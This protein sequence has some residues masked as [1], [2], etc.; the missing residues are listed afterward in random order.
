VIDRE[1]I[2]RVQDLGY[3]DRESRFLAVATLHAGAFIR[4]QF[5]LES[6]RGGKAVDKFCRKVV[7]RRHASPLEVGDCS[8]YKIAPDLY[9]QLGVSKPMVQESGL[10]RSLMGLDY[11]LAN[12]SFRFVPVD[13]QLRQG[14]FA[15]EYGIPAVPPWFP[16]GIDTATGRTSMAYIDDG[17]QS[18]PLFPA[19][20]EA[21]KRVIERIREVDVVYVARTQSAYLPAER[22]FRVVFGDRGA[23]PE[24]QEYFATRADIE[25]NGIGSRTPA[26]LNVYRALKT[27]FSDPKFER[28]YL[29]WLNTPVDGP[30]HGIRLT[31]F[32]ITYGY[33]RLFGNV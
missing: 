33:N 7:E 6:T 15:R 9:L 32:K 13:P 25:S 3:T 27:K 10:R 30:A 26:D 20:L 23:T 16:I 28:Q 1:H 14:Y 19:W 12:K 4:R 18:A 17:V 11:V 29:D 22:Q 21:N 2:N 24:L 31:T 8:V 5:T